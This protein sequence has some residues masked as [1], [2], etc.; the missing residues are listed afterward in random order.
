MGL[1]IWNLHCVNIEE[2][3]YA[4]SEEEWSA[5][6]FEVGNETITGATVYFVSNVSTLDIDLSG[7]ITAV[8]MVT[9]R[10]GLL[11]STNYVFTYDSGELDIRDLVKIK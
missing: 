9:L 10:K 1:N 2:V 3:Y 7:R 6:D 8:D 11:N 5:I 4:G